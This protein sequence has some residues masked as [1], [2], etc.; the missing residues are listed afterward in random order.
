MNILIAGSISADYGYE[1]KQ[2]VTALTEELKKSG[3]RVDNFLLPYERDMLSVI[4]QTLAYQLVD[5][6]NAD[7]LITV[8]YPACLIEHPKKSVYLF[9]MIPSYNEYWDTEY[10]VLASPQYSK[11]K[12]A[13]SQIE[14]NMLSDAHKVVCNSKLLADDLKKKH[15]LNCSVQ[16]FPLIEDDASIINFSVDARP[17]IVME[18]NL[19]PNN[20]I[21]HAIELIDTTREHRLVI[22]VPRSKEVYLEAL[23]QLIAQKQLENYVDVVRASIS[24]KSLANAVAYLSTDI[25][26][27]RIPGVVQRVMNQNIPII[28]M[29]DSGA[30][31]EYFDSYNNLYVLDHSTEKFKAIIKRIK[32]K[33]VNVKNTQNDFKYTSNIKEVVESLVS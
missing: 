22:F 11:I 15:N 10:G 26:N 31:C 6:K 5:V 20:R 8:G 19:Y 27:R 7:L 21:E 4:E 3:H 28:C 33:G 30:I 9:E 24:T 2:L 13:I 25:S 1:E 18:T 23:K 14:S 16:Y 32:H 17:Y 29:E 12:L